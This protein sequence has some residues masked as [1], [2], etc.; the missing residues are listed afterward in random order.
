[1]IMTALNKAQVQALFDREAVLLGSDDGVPEFR[2]VELFGKDAVV[3]AKC[4]TIKLNWDCTYIGDCVLSYLTYRG[5]QA[6]ASYRNVQ[7]LESED[8]TA[9]ARADV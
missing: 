9:K 5:F 3:R 4:G 1:M 6:A 2:A 8:P 7:L